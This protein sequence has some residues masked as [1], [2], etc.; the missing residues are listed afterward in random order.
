MMHACMY[1]YT[2]C[3][4]KSSQDKVENKLCHLQNA[5]NPV[6]VRIVHTFLVKCIFISAKKVYLIWK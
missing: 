5:A 6:I 1:E 2:V 4:D 3:M